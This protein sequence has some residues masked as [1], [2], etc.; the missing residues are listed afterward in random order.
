[1]FNSGHLL[2]KRFISRTGECWETQGQKVQPNSLNSWKSLSPYYQL[3]GATWLACKYVHINEFSDHDNVDGNKQSALIMGLINLFRPVHFWRLYWS[4]NWVKF[5]F[6]Y[7]FVVPQK[8]FIKPFEAP[9]R[10]MKVKMKLNFFSA[11]GLG[12]EGSI[13]NRM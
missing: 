5:L 10:S 7:F 1:M 13:K 2:I 8:A 9:Q 4:K 3:Q 11:S 12:R 6:S